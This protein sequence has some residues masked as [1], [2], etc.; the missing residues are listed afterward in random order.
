MSAATG[1]RITDPRSAFL[2][3]VSFGIASFFADMTY[4]GMR[5]IAGPYLASLGASGAA[6]GVIA[7]V[8]EFL[9]YTLRLLSG[10]AADRTRLYWPITLAGYT[11]QMAAVPALALTGAWPAAAALIILE[12][13]GKAV[14][15]PPRDVMLSRAG[16]HIGQGWAFGLHEALDQAGATVGPL[17]AA[18]VLAL[19]Q[20]YR[21][22]FAWLLLPAAATLGLVLTIRLRHPDAGAAIA[23]PTTATPAAE[24]SQA[25][26]RV[27]WLY[28]AGAALVAFGFSDFALISYHFARAGAVPA[29]WVPILYALAMPSAAVGSLLFG[30]WYDRRGLAVLIPGT[31]L[32]ALATPL[33]F[34]GGFAAAVPAAALWGLGLGLHETVMAAAVSSMVP[35]GR[36]ARAYG[37]FAAVFGTAWLV[38]SATQGA[39]YDVSVPLMVAVAV[40]AQILGLIPIRRAAREIG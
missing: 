26:P 3:V 19:H 16:E 17:I 1:R 23:L 40:A 14:R 27:F 21:T 12:R 28:A 33:A 7:G 25:L 15:N 18:L 4:E 5:G 10:G 39:L 37:V 29:V 32:V 6:V 35:A 34:L 20:N 9:G 31:L 8:G 13:V 22:A 24:S 38:G 36:R 2:F 11:V 30:R